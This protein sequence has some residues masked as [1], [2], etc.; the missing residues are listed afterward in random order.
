MLFCQ[1]FTNSAKA[2]LG[3]QERHESAGALGD[4]Q[5]MSF[6]PNL[7]SRFRKLVYST[8]KVIHQAR[9]AGPSHGSHLLIEQ[10]VL[11]PPLIGTD[12]NNSI[13]MR[14]AWRSFPP[15]KHLATSNT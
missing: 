10:N 12:A 14:L 1:S 3:R 5:S 6:D 8:Q 15:I 4:L 13:G 7:K 11:E 2:A 9:K